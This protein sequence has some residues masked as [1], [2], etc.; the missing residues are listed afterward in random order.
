MADRARISV[1]IAQTESGSDKQRNIQR[2][3]AL[4]NQACDEGATLVALPETFD[5]RG[6]AS[7]IPSVAEPLPGS[8]LE[9]LISLAEERRVWILAGSVHETNGTTM[10]P[11]NTSVLIDPDGT[12]AAV[13]RKIHLFNITIGDKSVAE[14][15]RYTPGADIVTSEAAGMKVGLTICYDVRFPELYRQIADVGA[16]LIFIP[17]SFTAAT[18]EAHWETLVRARAIENQCFVMAPGQAGIGGGEIPTYGNSMIV[19]PWGRVLARA[20]QS[21]ECV[22]SAQLDLAELEEIRRRLPALHN[23]MLPLFR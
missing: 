11:Y 14:S 8:A 17:A 21:G 5:Y 19:D 13:Y 20:P 6:E 7:R 22:V 12:I 9:P 4:V 23:R 3:V 16:D 15:N 2:A 18:G 10:M 1:A